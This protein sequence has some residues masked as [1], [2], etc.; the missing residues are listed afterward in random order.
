VAAGVTHLTVGPDG[1]LGRRPTT[2]QDHYVKT[3]DRTC[4]APGCTRPAQRCDLDHINDH[5]YSHDTS[6]A[7]LCCLC[8]RH[9]RAKHQGLHQLRRGAHGIDWTTPHQ[10]RYTVIHHNTN[11]PSPLER[12]LIDI[13]HGHTTPAKLRR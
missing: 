6:I 13:T 4:R 12:L 9:H 2:A 11:P 7:N 5:Q 10:H 1:H 3:R 8:R